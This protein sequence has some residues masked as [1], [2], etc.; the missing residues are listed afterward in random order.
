MCVLYKWIC[1]GR[2][3]C[4]G[5]GKRSPHR[6]SAVYHVVLCILS[7]VIA[8]AHKYTHSYICHI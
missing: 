2:V 8:C 5:K 6:E 1:I 7:V 3:V 4:V